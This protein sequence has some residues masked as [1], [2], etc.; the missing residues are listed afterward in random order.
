VVREPVAAP[1]PAAAIVEPA[2]AASA[3][4]PRKRRRRGGRGRTRTEGGDAAAPSTTKSAT[5]A[6]ASPA[7]VKSERKP[8]REHAPRTE[9]TNVPPPPPSA[10][11]PKPGFFRRI[12][13]LFSPR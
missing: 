5:D 12:A 2:V 1:A 13:R 6:T 3:D 7:H 11:P 9:S 4:A 8:R 10:M